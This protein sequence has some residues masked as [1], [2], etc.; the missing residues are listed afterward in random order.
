MTATAQRRTAPDAVVRRRPVPVRVT[1]LL[2]AVLALALIG[3]ASIAFGVRA[4]T[5]SDV[6]TGF[7]H[8]M[9]LRD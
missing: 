2:V 6:V 1:W 9:G 3:G 5:W 7:R 8:T 4:V